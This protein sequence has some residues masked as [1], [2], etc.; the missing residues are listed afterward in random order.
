MTER[1]KC[2]KLQVE[3]V[4]AHKKVT[5]DWAD[6]WSIERPPKGAN[7]DW[8]S[9]TFVVLKKEPEQWRGVVDMR[10]L[11]SQTRHVNFP[12]PKIEDLLPK[13]GK[14]QIFPFWTLK[15]PFTSN[16]STPIVGI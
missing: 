11:N 3:R 15:W 6:H 5:Q 7:M 13:Q 8:L 2:F 4:E 14:C 12:L 16:L 1:Q 9:V 10:G